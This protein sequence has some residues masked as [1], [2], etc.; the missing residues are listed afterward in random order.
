MNTRPI[1][2]AKAG[3]FCFL[4]HRPSIQQN[5][6][7]RNKEP[8]SETRQTHLQ[9]ERVCVIGTGREVGVHP[10]S[11]TEGA[12]VGGLFVVPIFRLDAFPVA[13]RGIGGTYGLT[14][15]TGKIGRTGINTDLPRNKAKRHRRNCRL[16]TLRAQE[17]SHHG[18]IRTRAG[19]R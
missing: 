12:P 7:Q 15:C 17:R 13:G 16:R 8:R 9:L 19:R 4:I 18:H 3:W 5:T 11:P 10:G 1:S 14:T 6:P 2:V